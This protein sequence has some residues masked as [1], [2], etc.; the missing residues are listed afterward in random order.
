[1]ILTG[2]N[3]ITCIQVAKSWRGSMAELVAASQLEKRE[4]Q[5]NARPSLSLSHLWKVLLTQ[6]K[7][8]SIRF[9]HFN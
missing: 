1:M 7:E 9:M 4:V 6:G 5:R 2:I 3:K 8:R